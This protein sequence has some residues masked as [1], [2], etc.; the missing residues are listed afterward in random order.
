MDP[1]IAF[2]MVP[3]DFFILCDISRNADQMYA[4]VAEFLVPFDFS[5]L[6]IIKCFKST[7]KEVMKETVIK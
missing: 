2:L 4:D 3:S 1:V 5:H 6:Q 7:E